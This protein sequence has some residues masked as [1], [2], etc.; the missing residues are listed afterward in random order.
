MRQEGIE[1]RMTWSDLGWTVVELS[2][3]LTG[4]AV[5]SRLMW[6]VFIRRVA[7]AGC[8][9]CGY[10]FQRSTTQGAVEY[11]QRVYGTRVV[12]FGP[13]RYRGAWVVRCPNCEAES[14]FGEFGRYV[15][16][17]SAEQNASREASSDNL[18]NP[19]ST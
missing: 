5:L 14:V 11:Y 7:L 17:Y 2:V 8:R 16:A 10:R 13:C 4:M 9:R 6:E 1:H 3:F 18:T 19:L 12:V 15:E